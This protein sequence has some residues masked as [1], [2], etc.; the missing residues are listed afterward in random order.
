MANVTELN[1]YAGY[2][3]TDGFVARLRA[4]V[5]EYREYRTLRGE[6]DALT[7]RDLSDIGISRA[8]I[9]DIARQGARRR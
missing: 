9:D 3:R 5:A 6:L 8:S 4:K 1:G 2:A 7:D